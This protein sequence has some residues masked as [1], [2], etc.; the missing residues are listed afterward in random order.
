[1]LEGRKQRRL[2]NISL[3]IGSGR[4]AIVGLSGAGKTSLLNVLAGFEVPTDGRLTVGPAPSDHRLFRYWVPQNGGLWPHIGLI[5]H[6]TSVT[7]GVA[8][9]EIDKKSDEILGSFDLRHRSNA[10]PDELS[11]GERSRLALARALMASP[12]VL[13]ADEPL[14]HVDIVRK[15]EFWKA[16][17]E[18]IDRSATSFV[19]CSHEPE[20]VRR[21]AD[22]I[23]VMEKGSMIFEG[24]VSELYEDPPDLRCAV[25]LG[26]INWFTAEQLAA[27]ALQHQGKDC[28]VRPERINLTESRSGQCIVV[29]NNPCGYFH[30]TRLQHVGQG[31]ELNLI[32]LGR[33]FF[34][35]TTQVSVTFDRISDA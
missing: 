2:N 22:R 18:W 17:D 26:P 23:I 34:P 7:G 12:R 9:S 33:R 5:E 24:S 32:H 35:P 27:L 30:E 6:L 20:I 28:G 16:V 31:F 19:F 21:H 4:T 15:P 13:L 10:F 14:A 25:F 11:Q 29:Q 1:M 3:R 8:D